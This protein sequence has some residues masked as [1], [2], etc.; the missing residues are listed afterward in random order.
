MDVRRLDRAEALA[1]LRELAALHV[2]AIRSGAAMGFV[3]PLDPADLARHWRET[4]AELDG[5]ERVL[6]AAWLDGSLVGTAQLERSAPRNARHR[7]EVQRV[8]V[9]SSA[10][11]RGVGRALMEAVEAEA[12]AA[13]LEL[14]Y[15][16]THDDIGASRFYERIGWTKLGVVPRYSARPDGSLAPGA[17]FYRVLD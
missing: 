2:D 7:G 15:L 4:A 10:R 16:T 6:L 17:F 12:R 8:A 11:G 13:G 1:L 3:E 9:A 14:L 5:G